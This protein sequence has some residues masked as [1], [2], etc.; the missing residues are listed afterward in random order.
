MYLA[1]GKCGGADITRPAV[2]P[3]RNVRVLPGRPG[4]PSSRCAPEPRS[5]FPECAYSACGTYESPLT[6]A[7]KACNGSARYVMHQK[8]DPSASLSFLSYHLKK[9]GRL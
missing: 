3:L 7:G 8:L 6:Q 5:W 9:L 4:G 1:R 2:V